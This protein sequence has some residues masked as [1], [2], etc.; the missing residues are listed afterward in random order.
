M[1]DRK[2]VRSNVRRPGPRSMDR[3]VLRLRLDSP[4]AGWP[5]FTGPGQTIVRRE[6][7]DLLLDVRRVQ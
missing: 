3:V 7:G 2:L 1:F 6:G 5:D 4:A